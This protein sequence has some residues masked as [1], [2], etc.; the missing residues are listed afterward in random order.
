MSDEAEVAQAGPYQ[1]EV[2]EGKR[3]FWCTCGR[4]DTQPYC[5]GSHKG[6]SF[7]PEPFVA[8]A[9]ETVNLCGCKQTDDA[10]FCDG[11]HNLV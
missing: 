4:S 9:T 5:D 10:P 6:T 1:V 11:S 8:T 2:E 3:Y 7:Q